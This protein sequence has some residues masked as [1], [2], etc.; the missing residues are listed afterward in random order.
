MM[1]SVLR[2]LAAGFLAGMVMTPALA[3]EDEYQGDPEKGAKAFAVCRSCH[4]A[5]K[6]GKNLVGPN[7]YGIMDRGVAKLEGYSYSAAL[8]EKA[9]E[10]G[11]T[12][13]E[14]TVS[15]FI[16]NPQAYIKGTQMNVR[17]PQEKKRKD[18]IAYLKTL[19]D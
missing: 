17:V 6:G 9:G 16:K 7:L 5:D 2:I 19:H 4:T 14:E 12:W 13:N 1:N 10:E 18:I 11:F 3:S 8:K 15:E